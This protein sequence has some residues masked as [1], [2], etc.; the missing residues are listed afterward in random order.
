MASVYHRS[1]LEVPVA[2]AWDFVERYSRSE[3]H[4]F[5]VCTSER[6]VDD[7]RVVTTIDG[8]EIWEQ[9]VTVDPAL[10]RAVYTITGLNDSTHHQAEMR[11]YD[12]GDS[13]SSLEW[14]TDFLPHDI[15]DDDVHKSYEALFSDLVAAV[16]THE[17]K[18]S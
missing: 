3:V 12:D 17:V 8:Q 16:N 4:A 10:M 7:F 9:N 15:V 5:S 11:V 18:G 6:Q 14:I 13:E 1:H 2:I